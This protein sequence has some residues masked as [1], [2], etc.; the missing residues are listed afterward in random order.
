ML[1]VVGEV[2]Y[3]MQHGFYIETT[4]DLIELAGCIAR[5]AVV[6]TYC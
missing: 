6:Q 5:L 2:S 3:A 1:C 4:H